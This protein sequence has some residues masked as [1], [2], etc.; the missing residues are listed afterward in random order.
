MAKADAERRKRSGAEFTSADNLAAIEEAKQ[1]L[2]SD[3]SAAAPPA[4]A[5]ANSPAAAV[6]AGDAVPIDLPDLEKAF[7]RN[8]ELNNGRVSLLGVVFRERGG[9]F[10]AAWPVARPREP[11]EPR[12]VSR[13]LSLSPLPPLLPPATALRAPAPRSRAA[14]LGFAVAIVVEA[15]SGVGVIGQLESYAKLLGVLGPA[16]G[17]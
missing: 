17:F 2:A 8:V 15:A 4:A 1:A 5:A 13:R 10:R 11:S 16:S 3:G 12:A 9:C 6:A 14:M 7:A